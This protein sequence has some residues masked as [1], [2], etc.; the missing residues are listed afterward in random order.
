MN[1]TKCPHCGEDL[2]VDTAP[3]HNVDV[4][5]RSV[6]AIARCCGKGVMLIPFRRIDVQAY[7]GDRVEDDWGNPLKHG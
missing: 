1:N 6:V 7:Y 3:V 5:G 2:I 4:Y